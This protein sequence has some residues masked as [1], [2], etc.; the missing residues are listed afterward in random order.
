MAS[1]D[2][3]HQERLP[4][5][6]WE[7]VRAWGPK[8]KVQVAKTVTAAFQ[9]IDGF[10]SSRSAIWVWKYKKRIGAKIRNMTWNEILVQIRK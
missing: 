7:M 8:L 2:P 4:K 1:C 6:R 3:L 9:T 5:S 10:Y